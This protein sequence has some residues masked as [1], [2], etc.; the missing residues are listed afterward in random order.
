L[1]KNLRNGYDLD[2][3]LIMEFLALVRNGPVL[4]GVF[5]LMLFASNDWVVNF[6]HQMM[7]LTSTGTEML[8]CKFTIFADFLTNHFLNVFH[9]PE[10][11]A[12]GKLI[13]K[14]VPVEKVGNK[15]QSSSEIFIK[16]F[17]CEM[18]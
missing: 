16:D 15:L 6:R 17:I 4:L 11:S 9:V 12:T 7:K 10:I 5:T 18:F 3:N 8:F 13:S 1:L 14:S 2:E